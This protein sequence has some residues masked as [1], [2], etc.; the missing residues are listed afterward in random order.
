MLSTSTVTYSNALWA[1][2]RLDLLA[3][4]RPAAVFHGV[5]CRQHVQISTLA[6]KC[7]GAY[8]IAAP[9]ECTEVMLPVTCLWMH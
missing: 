8:A 9:A 5:K 3:C 2:L 6:L 4:W 1:D 7:T